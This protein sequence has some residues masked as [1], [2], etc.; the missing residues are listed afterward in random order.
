M[1]ANENDI[2]RSLYSLNAQALTIEMLTAI[3]DGGLR[4][5]L[6]K[7][8]A[9]DA[10]LPIDQGTALADSKPAF[11]PT[12]GDRFTL[13]RPHAS[14]GIGQVWLAQVMP[15][16]SATWRSRRFSRVSPSSPSS[17]PDSCSR[18][19]SL[20]TWSTPE[21]CRIYSL[22]KNAEGR[23]Y[24]AMR[25]IRGES[26]AVAIRLFHQEYREKAESATTGDGGRRNGASNF[27]ARPQVSLRVQCD[28][29]RPQPRL[30]HRD[31]K[32][33]NIM[34][35]HYGETLVVDWGLA[36]VIGRDDFAFHSPNGI[37][38]PVAV[39]ESATIPSR[40]E[41]GTTI[42][43]PAY[44]SPEQASG[45]IDQL[46]PASDVYISVRACTSC[47]TGQLAFRDEEISRRSRKYSRGFPTAAGR[48][49]LDSGAARVN[50]FKSDGQGAARAMS[51]FAHWRRTLNTGW[52]TSRGGYPKRP[53]ERIGR[54]I[55][56]HRNWA[57][58]AAAS[59]VGVAIVA[60]VAVVVIKGASAARRPP[61][62]KPRQL[63]YGQRAVEVYL[64]NVSEN[65]LL[66]QQDSVDIRTL[67]RDLLNSALEYYKDFAE[68]RKHDPL[69]RRQ[70]ANAYFRVGQLTKEI[71]SPSLAIDAF[72]SAQAI[73]ESLVRA[74]P[75]DHELEGRLAD[76]YLAI[77][78]I[79]SVLADFPAAMQTL[80]QSRAILERRRSAT[81]QSQLTDPASPSVTSRSALCTPESISPQRAWP[82]TRRL[83]PSSKT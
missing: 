34:L 32:P 2:R 23:P 20:A 35:G 17:E 75:Q 61:A 62:R 77:G 67:R 48:R 33:A 57:V 29:F 25:F 45:T 22:G 44:M 16:F 71:G 8:L 46:G 28:R 38:V 13:I 64:T 82:F 58:A 56:Q 11:Q 47:S 37:T 4:L 15:S 24:Y 74:N 63:Q 78:K 27:A 52:P 81:L 79:Q 12:N 83:V 41:Q 70:L 40:T 18:R 50:L 49:P 6:S 26:L 80:S 54:W 42:G 31:L 7:T 30:L 36:K 14:G 5:T 60:T 39:D 3:D 73:W 53:I 55:R 76:C 43:T 1:K 66:N 9:C 68:Q 19:K 59:L 51:R 10:T 69:L 21:S 72:R 65:T